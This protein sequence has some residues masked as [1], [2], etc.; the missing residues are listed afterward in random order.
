LWYAFRAS[1]ESRVRDECF[2]TEGVLL[3]GY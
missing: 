2:E 1:L 3:V